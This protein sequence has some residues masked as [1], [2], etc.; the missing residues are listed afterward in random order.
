VEAHNGSSWDVQAEMEYNGLGQRLG[1][2]AAGIATRYVM[3]TSTGLSASSD[4]PLS[5]DSAG[6]TT[7][8]LYGLAP[9]A[10]QNGGAWTYSLPD[11]ANTPRQLTDA[12]GE[13]VLAARYDP[14]TLVK[15]YF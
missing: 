3:D 6:D 10:E 15:Y 14:L 12:Q 8:Y 5:A 4:R 2:D 9:I 11:G 13:I 1:M 7:Y